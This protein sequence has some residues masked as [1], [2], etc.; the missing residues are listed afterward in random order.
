MSSLGFPRGSDERP[1]SSCGCLVLA[2]LIGLIG[3]AALLAMALYAT[4]P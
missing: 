4:S 3:G 1:Q 2:A